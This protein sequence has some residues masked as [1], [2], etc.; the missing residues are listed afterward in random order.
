LLSSDVQ[1]STM[2]MVAS[3]T[4]PPGPSD[5]MGRLYRGD[6]STVL[7]ARR[8]PAGDVGDADDARPPGDRRRPR[9]ADTPD[10][11]QGLMS[12]D[13][14]QARRP[15]DDTTSR[16]LAGRRSIGRVVT[17]HPQAQIL[18]SAREWR[19]DV[20]VLGTR[21]LGR[22]EGFFLASVSLGVVRNAPCPVLVCRGIPRGVRR[23]TLALDGSDHARHECSWLTRLPLGPTVR[24]RIVGVVEPER[25]AFAQEHRERLEAE[26][27]RA[28]R[29]IGARGITVE[30]IVATGVPATA[31]LEQAERHD[32][33]LLVVGARGAGAASRLFLGTGSE[34]VIRRARS[35][36]LVVRRERRP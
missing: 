25:A 26:L 16:V 22:I 24:I 33:D 15:V 21:G 27:N 32:T 31:I 13:V 11:S 5:G 18:A 34:S 28:A 7:V 12:T 2:T 20:I 1:F 3:P 30:P 35:P 10:F 23:V 36:V 14:R 17:S 4:R 19:A 29:L 8:V 9:A 6:S